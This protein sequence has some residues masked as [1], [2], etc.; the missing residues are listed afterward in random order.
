MGTNKKDSPL[1][2]INFGGVMGTA[3]NSAIRNTAGAKPQ[4]N[5]MTNFR[6]SLGNPL[7]RG[8]NAGAQ[9]NNP[10][11]I[12]NNPLFGGMVGFNGGAQSTSSGFMGGGFMGG[13]VMNSLARAAIGT[14]RQKNAEATPVFTPP[15]NRHIAENSLTNLTQPGVVKNDNLNNN[16]MQRQQTPISPTA[17]SNQSTIND[18][19]GQMVPGTYNRSVGSP[20]Q[21]MVEPSVAID[22]LT[23][24]QIDPTMDQSPSMPLPPPVDVQTG[25]TPNYE[26]NNL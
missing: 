5:Q 22:P 11:S 17:L 13:G 24:Q 18:V 2:M 21:Q 15:T 14:M 25:I 3:V 9:V 20:L 4:G 26:I 16:N 1:K 19:Y 8:F 23:G 6:N 10:Q 7:T 12:N